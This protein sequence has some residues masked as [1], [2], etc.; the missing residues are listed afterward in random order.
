MENDYLAVSTG[1][2]GII[3]M[4]THGRQVEFHT[5]KEKIRHLETCTTFQ[6]PLKMVEREI[7]SSAESK[8]RPSSKASDFSNTSES[9][10][11]PAREGCRLSSP[12]ASLVVRR[13]DG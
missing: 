3:M 6:D 9:V 5:L 10:P 1:N 2:L 7:F 12:F 8:S 13:Q 4:T 11:V